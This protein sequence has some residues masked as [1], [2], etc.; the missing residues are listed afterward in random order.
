MVI[1]RSAW[2]F[3]VVFALAAASTLCAQEAKDKPA[4]PEPAEEEMLGISVG[5]NF[6]LWAADLNFKS[7]STTRILEY[8]LSSLAGVQ[9]FGQMEVVDEWSVRLAGDFLFGNGASAILG[10]LGA[11][12]S[13]QGLLDDPYGIHFRAAILFGTIELED[14]EGDFDSGVG[15]EVGVGLT[16]RIDEYVEG[17]SFQVEALARYLKFDFSADTDVTQTD[18]EVGGF[19]LSLQVGF[20]Y[21]F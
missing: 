21:R 16:Y 10:S 2:C 1:R 7:E 8:E 12:Y 11:V 20:I 9:I 6:S 13:P 4:A 19:G 5:A 17:L 18:D 14:V 15:V 3:A